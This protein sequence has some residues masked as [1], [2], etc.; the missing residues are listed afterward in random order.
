MSKTWCRGTFKL[1]LLVMGSGSRPI[2]GKKFTVT[3]VPKAAAPSGPG[4]PPPSKP[5]ADATLS[6]PIQFQ[7]DIDGAMGRPVITSAVAVHDPSSPGRIAIDLTWDSPPFDLSNPVKKYLVIVTDDFVGPPYDDYVWEAAVDQ[8]SG[9]IIG[10]PIYAEKSGHEVVIN[11]VA[12][13]SYG[14]YSDP[15][16][17]AQ[18]FIGCDV[19]GPADGP[20]NPYRTLCEH[21]L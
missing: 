2:A 20:A 5:R 6:G 19:F 17:I 4:I 11:V 18:L 12:I 21:D 10:P 3:F 1:R 7:R 15:S 8:R 14:R 16:H 9:R 13:D